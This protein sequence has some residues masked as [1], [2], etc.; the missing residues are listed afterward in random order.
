MPPVNTTKEQFGS[1]A[2]EVSLLRQDLQKIRECTTA[3]ESRVSEIEDQVPPLARDTNSAYQMAKEANDRA[4]DLENRLR[5]N[6]IRIVGLPE[7]VEG[8]D[9]TAY[10]ESWLLDI[11]ARMF[12]PLFAVEHTHRAPSRPPQPGGTPR[13][14]LAKLLHYHDREMGCCN[15]RGNVLIYNIMA[16]EYPFTLTSWRRYRGVGPNSLM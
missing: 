13:P 3:V 16:P 12:P 1:N 14:M 4:D 7:K 2:K 15:R 8:R 6:K 5:R 10:L 9:P 11:V